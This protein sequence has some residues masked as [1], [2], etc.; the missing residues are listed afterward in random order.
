MPAQSTM[1]SDEKSRVKSV[2]STGK[3]LSAT[4]ARV[5]YAHPDPGSWAYTGHQG[6]LAFVRDKSSDIPYLRLVD[7]EGT[8]G[9]IWEYELYDGC[10]LNND[11]PFF[12][13]F[14]GDVS[15]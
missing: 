14:A 13:S 5:Y 12:H 4:L 1:T 7:L 10:V 15:D 9:T 2:L 11:R 6:A 3:I 8:R